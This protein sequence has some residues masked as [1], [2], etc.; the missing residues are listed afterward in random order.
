MSHKQ[1]AISAAEQSLIDAGLVDVQHLDSTIRVELKYSTTDNFVGVDVY[2]DLVKA[3]LQEIPAQKLAKAQQYLK[4]KHPDYSLLVYDAARS[5]RVQQ[6]LWDTLQKPIKLKPLYVADPKEGSIHNYGAAVDLTIADQDGQ[7]LD[8][9]TTYDFFGELAYPSKEDSLL[10]EGKLT[11]EQ[12]TN[13]KL[14]RNTMRRAGFSPIESEWWH[15]NALSLL[16]CKEEYGI[17][18]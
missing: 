18:P 5:K 8:M 15:F 10:R 6:I 1:P 9:G 4:D 3:Y 14:L 7:P 16:R 2:G 12:I 17:I 11:Q 13:R